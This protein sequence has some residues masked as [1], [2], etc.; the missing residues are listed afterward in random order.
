MTF[1]GT[2]FDF[3]MLES[4]FEKLSG[5]KVHHVGSGMD[6][7]MAYFLLL[8]RGPPQGRSPEQ[9]LTR[10]PPR[11]RSPEQPL[12]RGPPG[13]AALKN[14]SVFRRASARGPRAEALGESAPPPLAGGPY[15]RGDGAETL[16]LQ[17]FSRLVHSWVSPHWHVKT[18]EDVKKSMASQAAA[19]VLRVAEAYT[20]L[21]GEAPMDRASLMNA[22]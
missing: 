5:F 17:A 10:G 7:Y 22:L 18:R 13:V 16:N 8:T 6:L 11:G 12:T 2:L 19:A 15:G 9:P 1:S 21:D 3:F 14:P 4:S 20:A